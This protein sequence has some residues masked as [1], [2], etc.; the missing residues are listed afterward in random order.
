MSSLVTVSTGVPQGSV[1]GPLLFI[2]YI[3]DLYHYLC[4]NKC[5]FY[6]DDTSFITSSADVTEL[7]RNMATL[8]SKA[9]LWFHNN[10]LQLNLEKTQHLIF[11]TNNS[12]SGGRSAKLLGITLDDRLNW[13][14]H[15]NNLSKKLSSSIFVLRRLKKLLNQNT[16][17]T[18][19][20]SLFHS[21]LAYGVLLWGNSS[22]SIRTFR[23]QKKAIRIIA[24]AGYYDH[25]KPIF[26]KF[27]VMPLPT[28][29]IYY[30]L[31]EIHK[32]KNTYQ[33]N[34]DFH[35]YPT[36]T[37]NLIR[38]N[39][40]KY[41]KCSDNSLDISLYNVLPA[42]VKSLSN[43]KFKSTLKRVMRSH[44]FYSLEEYMHTATEQALF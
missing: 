5:T 30:Q 42:N 20:F 26:K 41:R 6:A 18:V 40:F 38:P 17:L 10:N 8:K 35:K 28:L 12:I 7:E 14:A 31:L 39:K 29:F 4:P 9:D 15:I 36:R 2:V 22:S 37:A 33:L 13:S 43:T 23:L 44:C 32:K 16:L 21:H 27:G 34:A 1:L 3:N 25:C 19:Y 11:S 24:G